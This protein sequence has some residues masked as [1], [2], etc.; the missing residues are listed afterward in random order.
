LIHAKAA[1]ACL[2]PHGIERWFASIDPAP[3]ATS[4][5][6]SLQRQRDQRQRLGD[7]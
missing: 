7:R 5:D 2:V 4:G 3:K 1:A 6:D